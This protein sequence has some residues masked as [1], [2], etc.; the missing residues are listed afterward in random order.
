MANEYIRKEWAGGVVK[1][2]LNGAIAAG[3]TTIVLTD[4]STFPAGTFPFVVVIDRGTATEEKV[5]V[6]T[7]TGNSL[8][9]LQRGYDGA[10]AQSH[11]SGAYVEHVLDA[12]TV[13]QANAMSSKM[14]T[15]G[16]LIYKQTTGDNTA[17]ARLGIGTSGQALVSTGSAPSWGQ[18]G[19]AGVADASITAAKIAAAVAG[20]GLAGGAG[21]ALSVNVDNSTLEI[22]AD[23]LRVKN[24]GIGT[25]KLASASPAQMLVADSVGAPTWRT[26]TGDVTVSDTGATAIAAG[27][28]VDADVNAAAAIA[29]SK[30][31]LSNSIVNADISTAAAITKNKL[32]TAAGE[33]AGAWTAFTPTWTNLT[34]GNGTNVGR[35]Y[36][37]GKTVHFSATLSWGTTTSA[38]TAGVVLTL[39]VAAQTNQPLCFPAVYID[40]VSRYFGLTYRTSSTTVQV[41]YN[42]EFGAEV[43]V[44][45]IDTQPFVWASGDGIWINGTYEAA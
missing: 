32:S 23:S 28:I 35:Y 21:T 8:T 22:N 19:T 37:V 41:A 13:D 17:F 40:G 26:L 16:D 1:T 4:G 6:Q 20:D 27:A 29:Y 44:P 43:L 33:V 5:L 42:L 31:A 3:T 11:I 30:L 39:P 9:V 45:I 24:G 34:V 14:T 15:A 12:Y 38:T 2:T 18:V 25:A 36:Q 7:R 10:S